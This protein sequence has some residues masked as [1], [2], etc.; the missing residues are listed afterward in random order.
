MREDHAKARMKEFLEAALARAQEL[1]AAGGE[2][3]LESAFLPEDLD[4]VAF[5]DTPWFTRAD[6]ATTIPKELQNAAVLGGLFF[7]VEP[8][9][10]GRVGKEIV[11]AQ[12]GDYIYRIIGAEQA[13]TQ[14]FEEAVAKVTE[15]AEK[16]KAK[17]LAAAAVE[18]WVTRIR[19]TP[20]ATLESVAAEE[21]LTVHKTETPLEMNQGNQLRIDDK[22]VTAGFELVRAVF[23]ETDL[24]GEIT[25]PVVSDRDESVYLAALREIVDPDMSNFTADRQRLS[26]QIRT[27][28]LQA[29]RSQ[30]STELARRA[31]V[32]PLLAPEPDGGG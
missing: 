20:G 30:F 21:N 18:E 32:T 3:Q 27:R 25:A 6:M 28:R 23:M 13:H 4:K 8:Q 1:A 11:A 17:E 31:N 19:T 29:L 5:S 10:A 12:N 14:T 24:P 22:P 2:W 9:T 15:T 26:D 16:R 7:A